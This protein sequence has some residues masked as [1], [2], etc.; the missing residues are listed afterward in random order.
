[1]LRHFFIL[2]SLLAF[3]SSIHAVSTIDKTNE[4][5]VWQE[6]NLYRAKHGWEPLKLNA[7]M[8]KEAELHS[9]EMAEHKIPF[10]HKKFQDRIKRIFVTIKKPNGGAENVA[11]FKKN[12]QEVVRLWLTSSGHRHNIQGHYNLTGI[13]VVRDSKG[14]LYYTQIFARNDSQA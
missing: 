6:V 11:Y 9:L 12:G 1:M 3:S 14:W 5:I 4:K 7:I 13:G 8:T 10:G 2:L